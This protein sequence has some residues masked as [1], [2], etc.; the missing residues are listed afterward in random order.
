VWD[1]QKEAIF[2]RKS[3]AQTQ[4]TSARRNAAAPASQTA[5]EIIIA[6][7][8]QAQ[9]VIRQQYSTAIFKPNEMLTTSKYYEEFKSEKVAK[10][11]STTIKNL[12]FQACALFITG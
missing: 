5:E 10:L 11:T 8:A 1:E 7:S 6:D 4:H 2:S 9:T 12:H 3:H